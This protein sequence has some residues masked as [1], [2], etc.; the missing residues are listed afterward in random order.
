MADRSRRFGL[1][2][3]V[4]SIFVGLALLPFAKYLLAPRAAWSQRL[5]GLVA[6][7]FLA[8]GSYYC[9]VALVHSNV[10]TVDHLRAAGIAC[11]IGS[12]AAFLVCGALWFFGSTWW[13]LLSLFS[14]SASPSGSEQVAVEAARRLDSIRYQQTIATTVGAAL[15][16]PGGLQGS[17]QRQF[18]RDERPKPLPELVQDFRDFIQLITG[19]T[20]ASANRN[21][22]YVLIAIDELDKI[23]SADAAAQFINEVKSMFQLPNCYFLVSVSLDVLRSFSRSGAPLRDAFDSAFDTVEPISYWP[24]HD[25]VRLLDLRVRRMPRL[26]EVFCYAHSGGLPRDLIRVA[27][28]IAGEAGGAAAGTTLPEL[29][30]PLLQL[31]ID[32]LL[33]AALGQADGTPEQSRLAPVSLFADAV[34]KVLHDPSQLSAICQQFRQASIPSN[35]DRSVAGDRVPSNIVT[36]VYLLATLGEVFCN[37]STRPMRTESGYRDEFIRVLEQLARARQSLHSHPETAWAAIRDA[38]A[39]V[40]LSLEQPSAPDDWRNAAAYM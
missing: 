21:P 36:G 8:A 27:R 1:I 35:G 4:A 20:D 2:L 5:S 10:T 11:A 31:D 40:G 34:R 39:R 38:R 29:I 17:V 37:S 30:R 3:G 18:T 12:A 19:A 25:C 6:L 7:G 15:K 23:E 9:Y 33:E 24:V 22:P 26:A 28:Q 14:T 32:G 16:G 13:R